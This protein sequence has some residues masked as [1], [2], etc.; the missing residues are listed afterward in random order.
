MIYITNSNP[1]LVTYHIKQSYD[2]S[3]YHFVRS[4]EI[5]ELKS[6]LLTGGTLNEELTQINPSIYNIV[7][8]TGPPS[9]Q[10]NQNLD[11]IVYLCVEKLTDKW[12]EF[13]RDNDG[14]IIR[15]SPL[16]YKS[17]VEQFRTLFTEDSFNY[18][19][20]ELCLRKFKS[21]PN[22]W[23]VELT[24]L[25]IKV[26]KTE[27]LTIEKLET[28]YSPI[29]ENIYKKYI[30]NIG[31]KAGRQC[32]D[33]MSPNQLWSLFLGGPTRPAILSKFLCDPCR[34]HSCEELYLL[35]SLL[36]L[37]IN[38]N[39]ID[40]Y[41]GCLIMDSFIEKV[42]RERYKIKYEIEDLKRFKKLLYL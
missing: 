32:I 42:G 14:K 35:L 19:W 27:K 37:S 10:L 41:M 38:N 21:N 16:L 17:I 7:W 12:E 28:L 6:C 29:V 34:S 5:N 20:E 22:K 23:V 24:S 2:C 8:E 3:N 11:N 18:F 40:L 1:S 36:H 31:S 26:N 9:I 15:I 39:C 25:L 13:A 4:K 30:D 33:Q